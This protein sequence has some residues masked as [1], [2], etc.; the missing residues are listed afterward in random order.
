MINAEE[1]NDAVKTYY[2]NLYRYLTKFIWDKHR[3]KDLI[4]DCYMKLWKH[5]ENIDSSKIKSWLFT[6][7]H[8]SMM[9]YINKSKRELVTSQ[10]FFEDIPSQPQTKELRE[11]IDKAIALLPEIQRSII[12][13][14][15]LEGY[16]YKEIGEMLEIS[17]SQVKV[18]L[19]RGRKKVKEKLK[20]L[21]LILE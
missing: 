7:A 14:R 4:Q 3:V 1:Y 6:T 12:L 13:L 11:I 9:D 5:R 21:N 16:E 19:F 2:S 18:Y 10:I 8:N 20:S 15:D 17:D